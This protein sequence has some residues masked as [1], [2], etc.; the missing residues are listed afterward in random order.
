MNLSHERFLRVLASLKAH[1]AI[2]PEQ[3]RNPR[4]G[5]QASVLIAP[6]DDDGCVE[7]RSR[8]T[9]PGPAYSVRVRDLGSGGISFQHYHA[10]PKGKPFILDLPERGEDGEPASVRLLCRVQH[11][12]LT[13][14]HQF[15]IG[16]QFIRLWTA[17]AASLDAARAIAA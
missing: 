3:R 5:L 2:T 10:L 11:C 7:S 16:A 9:A 1:D 15:V 6:C 13:A 8:E 12:R 17:P 14:E 4:V